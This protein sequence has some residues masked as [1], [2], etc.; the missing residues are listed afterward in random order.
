[1][2]VVRKR[3]TTKTDT[4]NLVS[5]QLSII[6][7]LESQLKIAKEALG[8]YADKANWQSDDSNFSDFINSIDLQ[9]FRPNKKAQYIGGKLA[10]ETLEKLR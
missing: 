9:E 7:E 8:F 2:K 3:N 5:N 10:R 4:E 6:L 1:M